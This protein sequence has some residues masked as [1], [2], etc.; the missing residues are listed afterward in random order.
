MLV[1]A[2]PVRSISARLAVMPLTLA[3]RVKLP[4]PVAVT[5]AL[6]YPLRIGTVA[7]ERV[8]PGLLKK[9]VAVAFQSSRATSPAPVKAS[10]RTKIGVPGR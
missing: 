5:R 10:M 4:L 9:S 1:I 2:V 6:P 7:V 3:V 8:T